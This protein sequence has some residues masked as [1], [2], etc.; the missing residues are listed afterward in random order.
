MWVEAWHLDISRHWNRGLH[1]RGEY[2]VPVTVHSVP[3]SVYIVP[4]SVA[5]VPVSVYTV[6]VSETV[7]PVSVCSVP[8]RGSCA[9]VHWRPCNTAH[10][11]DPFAKCIRKQWL[12]QK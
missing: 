1:M 4:V 3:V 7:V 9:S 2:S 11:L 12:I 6:P 10:P 8:V 5:V